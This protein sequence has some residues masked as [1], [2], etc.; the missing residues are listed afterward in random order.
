MFEL[1]G[2]AKRFGEREALAP[3]D[4]V[5]PSGRTL[6]L[7]GPSGCGKSTLLRLMVGLLRPDEGEVRFAG[8]E[9]TPERAEA[10]RR[11]M[12]F[13]VQGGGLFPHLNA[14][15][16]AAIMAQYLE[17]EASRIQQRIDFLAQLTKLPTDRF[18]KYPVEI[19]GGER[20]RVSLIRAL[21]LDPDVLLLDEP[22]GALDPM[23]RFELQRDLQRIFAQLQ[24]TVVLVTHD[25]GEAAFFADEIVL[26]RAG[27]I[28][29]RGTLEELLRSPADPFVTQFIN[30]QRPPPSLGSAAP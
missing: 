30:A 19:S 11:R 29:Q 20:Q 12:G 26:L 2:V 25:L 4:L 28:I 6:V 1:R 5:V 8:T 9:L 18:G 24:K 27:R 7:I 10:L 23:T 13:V 3:T 14:R 15:Q 16:N 17:W 21:M 22:L